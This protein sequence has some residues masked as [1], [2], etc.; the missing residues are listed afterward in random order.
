MLHKNIGQSATLP[1]IFI[2][3]NGHKI[4]GGEVCVYCDQVK[5]QEYSK[6]FNNEPHQGWTSLHAQDLWSKP[7]QRDRITNMNSIS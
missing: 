5:A 3:R 1:N 4:D 6:H 7:G 2:S